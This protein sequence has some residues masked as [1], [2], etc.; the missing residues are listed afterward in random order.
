MYREER[1]KIKL[2]KIT[3]RVYSEIPYLTLTTNILKFGFSFFFPCNG[4]TCMHMCWEDISVSLTALLS[5]AD[6]SVLSPLGYWFIH[7]LTTTIKACL[8][9]SAPLL[10]PTKIRIIG[11][12]FS[13]WRRHSE[14]C[15]AI[16][17]HKRNQKQLR[18][19]NLCETTNLFSKQTIERSVPVWK[20]FC[21]INKI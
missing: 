11:W 18:G 21:Q 12:P 19:M 13:Y 4:A 10:F 6:N 9:L 3:F 15:W 1:K 2:L 8:G 7:T 14:L 17:M 16:Q 20:D 5:A